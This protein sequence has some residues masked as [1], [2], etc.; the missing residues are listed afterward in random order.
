MLP[1][2]R[3]WNLPF[4]QSF[5]TADVVNKIMSTPILHTTTHDSILW[6]PDSKGIYSV[7]TAYHLCQ[8]VMNTSEEGGP[9]TN[10][11]RIWHLHVSPR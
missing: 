7:R 2:L 9:H 6:Q 3:Q 11:K 1:G 10:W 5:L 8:Q 4:L